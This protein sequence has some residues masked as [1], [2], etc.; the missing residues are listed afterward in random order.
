[1]IW[2]ISRKEISGDGWIIG[3]GYFLIFIPV[4]NIFEFFIL[5]YIYSD[6]TK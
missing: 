3:L 2:I 5:W 6:S 1:M 4:L